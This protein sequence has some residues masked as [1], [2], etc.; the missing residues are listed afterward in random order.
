M[1]KAKIFLYLTLPRI[2]RI[3]TRL[4]F[5]ISAKES[6]KFFEMFPSHLK[7][8][9]EVV[10][11]LIPASD[12]PPHLADYYFFINSQPIKIYSRIYNPEPTHSSV[13]NLTETQQLI[14][15]C[16]YTRHHNGFVEKNI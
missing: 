3:F 12:L 14:L 1:R 13:G 15:G 9:V 2:Y 16:I 8:D 7:S 10:I 4:V 6:A 5:G 11:K